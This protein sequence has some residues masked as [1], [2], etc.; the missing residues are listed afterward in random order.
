MVQRRHL[1]NALAVRRLKVGDLNDVRE[2]FADVDD[3]D[4]QQHERHIV[5]ERQSRHRAAEKERAGVAHEY[6]GGMEVIDEKADQSADH[7]RGKNAEVILIAP[8]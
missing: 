3:A 8:P 6:L 1:E 2:R 5:G 4:E 7:R